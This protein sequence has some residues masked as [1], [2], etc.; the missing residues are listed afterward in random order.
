[1][2][3]FCEFSP[4]IPSRTPIYFKR[5]EKTKIPKNIINAI[6]MLFDNPGLIVYYFGIF[7]LSH[8]LQFVGMLINNVLLTGVFMGRCGGGCDGNNG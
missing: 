1:V 8:V 3:T 5:P 6:N 4:V 2:T 7:Y